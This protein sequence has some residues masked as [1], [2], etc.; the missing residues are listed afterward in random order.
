[1]KKKAPTKMPALLRCGLAVILA[2]GLM[3]PTTGLSAYGNQKQEVTPVLEVS[4]LS[5]D[6]ATSANETT[7]TSEVEDTN[8]TDDTNSAEVVT[9]VTIDSEEVDQ[10]PLSESTPPMPI[11]TM[12]PISR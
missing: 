12:K 11:V 7:D 5:A 4:D 1:M 10:N 6:E 3:L 8:S 9:D 2:C